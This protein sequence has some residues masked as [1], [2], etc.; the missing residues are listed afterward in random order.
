MPQKLA[1]LALLSSELGEK[2]MYDVAKIFRQGEPN[3]SNQV[4]ISIL[5]EKYLN[6]SYKKRPTLSAFTDAKISMALYKQWQ[7]LSGLQ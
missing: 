1:D 7:K 2:P 6:L 3:T 4:P 5:T